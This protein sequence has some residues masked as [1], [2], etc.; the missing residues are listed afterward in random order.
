MKI[1]AKMA[2]IG[3]ASVVGMGVVCLVGWLANSNTT[4]TL[5]VSEERT[6]QA[7]FEAIDDTLDES[8]DAITNGLTALEQSLET[9][10]KSLE[11]APKA[12][13]L[14]AH[15]NLNVV[16]VQQWLTDISA[17]RAQEGYADSFTEAGEHAKAFH[18][19]ATELT[20]LLPDSA[21][22]INEMV[23]SFEAFH[24]KGKW[25][26]NQYI[27]LGYDAGNKATV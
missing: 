14:A 25:M 3:V 18:Q 17:T 9:R 8:G 1:A 12:A 10:M 6:T 13:A 21:N 23:E 4:E 24:E 19:N 26:A 27:D 22:E 16:Q 15:A 5:Q 20:E 11:N 7:D 2:A